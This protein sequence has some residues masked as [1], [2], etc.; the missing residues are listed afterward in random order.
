V[1]HGGLP[2]TAGRKAVWASAW[3]PGPADEAAR[4]AARCCW[5]AP[6]KFWGGAEQGRGELSSPKKGRRRLGGLVAERRRCSNDG[7]FRRGSAAAWGAPTTQRRKG[8]VR[9]HLD[10]K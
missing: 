2:R 10:L 5:L 7:E 3:R 1:P 4:D 6:E 9:R 8:G